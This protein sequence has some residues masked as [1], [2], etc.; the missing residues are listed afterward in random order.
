MGLLE[1]AYHDVQAAGGKDTVPGKLLHVRRPRVL[2]QVADLTAA[3]DFAACRKAFAGKDPG[4]GCLAGAV[5]SDETNFVPPFV[6]PEVDL[7]HEQACAGAE[8]EV[9]DGNQFG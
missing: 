2:R 4:E 1:L 5:A 8:F 9:L 6:H 7:V 3:G